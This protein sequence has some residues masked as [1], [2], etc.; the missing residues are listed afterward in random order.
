[1]SEVVKPWPKAAVANA[2]RRAQA[3]VS[4]FL[5]TVLFMVLVGRFVGISA[6]VAA[7]GDTYMFI[8]KR[9]EDRQKNPVKH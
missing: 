6:G 9:M 3:P 8:G 4:K 7:G 1:M 2:N 5:M